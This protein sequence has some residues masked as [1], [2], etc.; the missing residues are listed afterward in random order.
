MKIRSLVIIIL[1]LVA[2]S[3]A[4]YFLKSATLSAKDPMEG[5]PLFSSL[6]VNDVAS[7]EIKSAD[8]TV[9]LR[10]SDDQWVVADKSDYPADY[11]KVATLLRG[12][13][14]AEIIRASDASPD[15]LSRLALKD[16]DSGAQA[17]EKGSRVLLKDQKGTVIAS[18]L[19]GSERK[20][21]E[22]NGKQGPGTICQTP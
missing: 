1:L 5:K 11:N 15:A 3:A 21:P 4:A 22:E 19:I 20:A 6:P 9:H 7:F 14:N 18:I 16:P 10:F 17:A 12:L 13:K 2:A 8:N